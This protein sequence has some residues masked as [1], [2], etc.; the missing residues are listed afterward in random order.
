MIGINENLGS[1]APAPLPPSR[2]RELA[3]EIFADG[4]H[5]CEA[6]GLEH[7][8]QQ[9]NMARAV[10]SA[11]FSDKPL[12]FEAG[13]GVGK[14]LAYLVPGIIYAMDAKRQ[15]V[16]STH[17][18]S[19][20]EQLEKNDLPHCRK[21]FAAA[22]P[23]QHYA[24]FRS[25]V[26]VGK[27]NYLC[28]TR[29]AQAIRDKAELFTTSDQMELH[30]ITNW[31]EQSRD[32]LRHEL[33]PPPS[34]EV[35]E[36][37]NADSGACSKRN[38][39]C[40]RCFYQKARARV[41]AAHVLIVNHSLFFSL[42]NIGPPGGAGRENVR[43]VLRTDDFVVLDEAHTVPEVATDH[44]GTR[45][46]NIG[47]DRLLKSLYHP[48]KKRGLLAK[49]G[50]SADQ[51]AV[52]DALE[53]S[54]VFF[55]YLREKL[56]HTQSIVRVRSPGAAEPLMEE[57]LLKLINR[58]SDLWNRLPDTGGTTVRDE[59]HDKLD[60]VQGYRS[61][62]SLWLN[63]AT[64]HS[65]H[66]LERTGRRQTTITLRAAPLDVAPYLRDNLFRRK[67]SVIL[68]SATLTVGEKI[69]PF[70]QRAGADDARTQVE[71]SPF[72]FEKNMR[73][74][75]AQDMAPPT[76]QGAKVD[77]EGLADYIGYCALKV[78]GGSLVLFTSYTDMRHIA[79]VLAGVFAREQRPF[80]MQGT[81]GS[82][83]EL[84]QRLRA[85]GNGILF[86][87]DSFWTGVDVPGEA[88]SQVI[89]TRLPFDP[90][91]H[92]VT[93]ARAEWLRSQ[94][95]NPF[96]ELTLPDSL[97]KFRQG[98]GRLIRNKSDRGIITVLDARLLTKA[99]GREFIASLPTTEFTRLSRENRDSVFRPFP[100]TLRRSS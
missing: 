82:R 53:A 33:V 10:A 72:D 45:I 65:V 4:G 77:L 89:I 63:Q 19:L 25:A 39:D 95:R 27:S 97:M 46:S 71:H 44:T 3:L 94:G 48:T 5:L 50:S 28:T 22:A 79:G 62:I 23:L 66:W 16:V 51:Q 2:V 64:P 12:L 15:L 35:W 47:L 34:D 20:Q 14:S 26:L 76:T 61:D 75:I 68:S 93:E 59:I 52:E 91:T 87:T 100:P 85:V 7:R 36:L 8:P 83:T 88:L 90:P 73:V 42:L 55:E 54:A 86:G 6:L 69:E 67:T 81:D 41:E 38:C 11:Y 60:R 13:T 84:T 49:H 99:Y 70:Q 1:A 31:A 21:L 57:P 32:G 74:Y 37:V 18:I 24:Q 29:L 78:S 80:F 92:P 9:E 58:V 96:N 43:G 98:V 17:T 56:L 30:R 40:A